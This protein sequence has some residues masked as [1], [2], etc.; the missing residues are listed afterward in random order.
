MVITSQ[1][2][3]KI[4]LSCC[5]LKI[6]MMYVNYFWKNR[7]KACLQSSLLVSKEF[8][9]KGQKA[10]GHQEGWPGTQALGEEHRSTLCTTWTSAF[11]SLSLNFPV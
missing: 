1:Y 5:T 10:A 6:T 8:Q 3:M 7:K 2:Y 4:K 11:P 9:L